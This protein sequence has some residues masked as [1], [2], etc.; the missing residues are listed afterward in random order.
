MI[1][2]NE[3]AH[4]WRIE[5]PY[6]GAQFLAGSCLTC[7]AVRTDFIAFETHATADYRNQNRRKGKAS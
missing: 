6:P 5:S 4:R 3:H 7:G 2:S 1:Q